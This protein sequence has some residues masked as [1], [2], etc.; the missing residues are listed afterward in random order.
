MPP[1]L[2]LL[3]LLISTVSEATDGNGKVLKDGEAVKERWREYLKNLMNVK[4]G[5]PEK[6]IA[7]VLNGGGG[8]VYKEECIKYEE[9][10]QAIKRL[11]KMERQRELMEFQQ[12]C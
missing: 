8:G 7:A 9:V 5:Y 11:K 4:N 10:N 2:C 6:L 3:L 12:K 1:A